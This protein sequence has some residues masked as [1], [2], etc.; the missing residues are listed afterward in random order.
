M[1]NIMLYI[2][3]IDYL[4]E[5]TN[6]NE[7]TDQQFAQEAEKQGLVYTLRGFELAVNNGEADIMANNYIRFININSI[8]Q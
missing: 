8:T 3:D 2:I 4:A 7:L 5:G 6:P 1:N